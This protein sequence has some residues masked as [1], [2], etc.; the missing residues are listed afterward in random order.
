MVRKNDTSTPRSSGGSQRAAERMDVMSTNNT[1]TEKRTNG[2]SQT[3]YTLVEILVAFVVAFILVTI[4]V[5]LFQDQRQKTQ[6]V[7]CMAEI[8][9][10]QAAVIT[11]GDGRYIPPP[12]MFWENTWPDGRKHG[13]Y[14]YIVDGDPN[15]GHGNDLDG[16]DE[17]NPGASDPDK[18]DIKF[19][20]FCDHDHGDL[21]EYVYLTDEEPPQ[22]VHD[23]SDDPDYQRFIKWEYGGPGTNGNKGGKKK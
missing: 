15:S 9:G 10:I 12:E 2:S 14:Y 5:R 18:K 6:L 11:M 8:R 13:P 3:G 22:L 20:I 1:D 21:A 19:V 7:K 4:G 17:E 16:V 23:G